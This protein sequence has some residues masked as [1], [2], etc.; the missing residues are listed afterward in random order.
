M[1]NTSSTANKVAAVTLAFWIMKILAT[2]LGETFGDF[3]SMT[4]LRDRLGI[5]EFY[6]PA[7]AITFL[8]LAVV[9]Y[10]KFPA[11]NIIRFY[12]GPQS[13]RQPPLERKFRISWIGL[14][15]LATRS[16]LSSW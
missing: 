2:T 5:A 3:I 4:L 11:E 14:W 7:L 9:R 1:L 8:V 15:D 13:L 10:S 6:G 12:S 16:A